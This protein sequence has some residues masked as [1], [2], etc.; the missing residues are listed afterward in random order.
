MNAA[1]CGR[2]Q[3]RNPRANKKRAENMAFPALFDD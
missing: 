1:N 2:I 3:Y